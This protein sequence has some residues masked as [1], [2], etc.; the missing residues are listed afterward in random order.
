MVKQ[1]VVIGDSFCH[2]VG[3][4]SPFYDQQNTA[5]AFGAHLARRLD[6]EYVNLAEP[7][8]SVARAVDVGFNYVNEHKDYIQLLIAGWT[9]HCRAGFYSNNTALQIL[10]QYMMLGDLTD[11]DVFVREINSVKFVTDKDNQQHL[12]ALPGLHKIFV[13][14]GF[15]QAQL[16][17]AQTAVTCFRSWLKETGVKFYDFNVFPGGITDSR[18]TLTFEHVM[19][20]TRHPTCEEQK[21]FAELLFEEINE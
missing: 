6:L 17:S 1:L 8:S 21:R 2:G 12:D 20:P 4:V 3:T 16:T 13:A 5:N 19:T 11:N 18:S 14:N 15:L 7:G 10:P 9:Q